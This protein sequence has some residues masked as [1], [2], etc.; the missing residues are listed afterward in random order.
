MMQVGCGSVGLIRTASSAHAPLTSSTPRVIEK[1]KKTGFI[2]T[3]LY[4]VFERSG[5]RF[6]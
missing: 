4:S 6:A 2:A 3:S 5:Y 1:L